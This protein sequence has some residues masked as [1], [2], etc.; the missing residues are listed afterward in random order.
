MK[1]VVRKFKKYFIPHEGNEFR[2]HL[3]RPKAITFI[4]VAMIVLEI[5]FLVGPAY[6]ASRSKLF[7]IIIAN[8]LVDETNQNRVSN[9]LPGL[10]VSPLLQAAAQEKADDMAKYSYFAHTSPT[11]ITPWYWFQNVGYNFAY[12]GENLAVNFSDSA[13]VTTAWM[14]SPEHRANILDQNYT[15]I[16]IAAATGT[17]EGQS[18]VYVVELFGTP[19]A[20]PISFVDTAS[21]ASAPV[22]TVVPPMS[23]KV[24]VGTGKAA[25]PKTI[26]VVVSV[27]ASSASQTANAQQTFVAV[28]GAQT[29]AGQPSASPTQPPTPTP[30]GTASMAPQSNAAQTAAASPRQLTDYLYYLLIGVLALALGFNIFVRIRIQ[31]P[32]LIAGGVFAIAIAAIFIVLNQ[33]VLLAHGI[34]F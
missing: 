14:N 30:A 25:T 29:E 11:G 1:R 18:T 8:T 21:A 12:A 7:G 4:C 24:S 17:Y 27:V 26:P 5:A 10:T 16:G 19:A 23:A 32:S 9:N 3:L 34:I 28:K 2:P 20:T 22:A 31:Y 13:D 33:Q 6:F 15:Q